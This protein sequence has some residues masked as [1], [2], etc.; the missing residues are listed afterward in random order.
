MRGE[1]GWKFQL[2]VNIAETMI[3]ITMFSYI[4]KKKIRKTTKLVSSKITYGSIN[5][6]VYTLQL[7]AFLIVLWNILDALGFNTTIRLFSN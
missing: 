1:K 7:L 3:T 4:F 6:L 5:A 2:F